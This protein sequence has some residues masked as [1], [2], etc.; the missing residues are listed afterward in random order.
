MYDNI[1]SVDGRTG[2]KISTEHR[3]SLAPAETVFIVQQRER[4]REK[5]TQRCKLTIFLQLGA[6]TDVMQAM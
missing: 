2:A 6:L 1:V 5:G 4:E 3:W